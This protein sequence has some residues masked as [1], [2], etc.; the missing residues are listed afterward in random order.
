VIEEM[1]YPVLTIYI[2]IDSHPEQGLRELQTVLKYKFG[3]DV[4]ID[5]KF[6]DKL[7]KVIKD[8]QAFNGLEVD[9]RVG[10]ATLASLNRDLY[11]EVKGLKSEKAGLQTEKTKLQTEKTVLQT[12]LNERNGVIVKAKNALNDILKSI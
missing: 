8:Y 5:G 1:G 2:N 4:T 11:T 10:P 12:Q 6:D 3:Y 7:I 9:G